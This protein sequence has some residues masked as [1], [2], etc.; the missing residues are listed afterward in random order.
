MSQIPQLARIAIEHAR[1]GDFARALDVAKQA[2]ARHP[3]N[4]GLML[5]VGMLHERKLDLE[6]AALAFKSALRLK[7]SDPL[8]T[9][10]LARVLIA[11]NQ[12]DEADEL[13]AS[14]R[15]PGL[16]PLRLTG[17]ISLRR[18]LA[19]DA[20]RQFEQIVAADPRDFESWG[21]LGVARLAAGDASG[22]ADALQASLRLRR[23]QQR[24][25][26]K[27]VDAHIAAGTGEHGLGLALEF[28]SQ[29]P[30]DVLVRVTIARLHDLLGRP[31]QAL[32]AL[33]EAL[34]LD[35]AHAPALVAL[36]QLHERQNRID[37]FAEVVSRLDGLG[38]PTPELPVLQARL[39]FRRGDLN[40]AL[41]LAEEIS[42]ALDVGD[43]AH[44][45]GQISDRL[46][47]SAKAFEAFCEMNRT[48]DISPEL[49]AA[50][51]DA[52]R[53][54]IARRSRMATRKWVS[55]W[56]K[57]HPP[58][59]HRDPVFLVGFPRSGTT[60]L[61][62]LL[63]GHPQVCVTEEKPMLDAVARNLGGYECLGELPESRLLEL[64]ELYLEQALTHVAGLDGRVL[65]DKQPFA[66]VEAPLI[67]RLF[68]TAK[69]LFVQRHPC[70]VVLSC[71][72]ARFEPN[73]ALANFV[74]LEGTAR[75]YNELRKFW[76]QCRSILPMIVH[77]VRYERL[78]DDTEAEMRALLAFLGLE[79]TDRVLDH[80][81]TAMDRGFINTP[82]YSQVVEPM[83]DRSIGR[84]TRY[85]EQM[86]PVLH[87]L[88]PWARRMGYEV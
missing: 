20:A 51:A 84:W 47:D 78:V 9:L 2:V 28:A 30:G 49:L 82:S 42:A 5:F 4:Y 68:P 45:I 37:E 10:E 56:R 77:L 23:N 61:D 29:H 8:T 14:S 19:A 85:R 46:G 15:L 32:G 31:E 48:S 3:N 41:E 43:R 35:P 27:W 60:L 7:P 75:L 24:F 80:R 13:L 66:M 11:V 38:V 25:R 69:I 54:T 39:A 76:S 58:E 16:E 73:A 40:R 18:G 72:M 87:L 12:L 67:Y 17:L 1:K 52:Y 34:Q 22:A 88:E 83:F 79:W 44:L 86:Q 53:A 6:Q 62:T 74:T 81:S 57:W 26:D 65:V 59:D 70:D 21:N 64:R 55:S 63:M 50:R 36:A 33:N 71:F